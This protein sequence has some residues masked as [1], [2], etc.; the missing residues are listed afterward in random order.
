MVLLASALPQVVRQLERHPQA[1]R[2]KKMLVCAWQDKWENDSKSLQAIDTQHLIQSALQKHPTIESLSECLNRI[3][4]T[5][6]KKQEYQAIANAIVLHLGKLYGDS[7]EATQ[8]F[9]A[10]PSHITIARYTESESPSDGTYVGQP[11]ASE[12][13]TG[14]NP[15]DLR[16]EVM[17]YTNPLRV[18]ILLYAASEHK[19][20]LD[21]DDWANLKTKDLDTLLY[22]L[23]A[24]C[25]TFQQMETYLCAAADSLEERSECNQ[26]AGAILQ[27]MKRFY[28]EWEPGLQDAVCVARAKAETNELNAP[29]LITRIIADSATAS[30]NN[31][32]TRQVLPS[33]A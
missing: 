7:D 8:A 11:Q 13:R 12:V 21:A 26:A 30:T 17:R 16:L 6:N 14:Y 18:K 31:T 1:L 29:S 2:M 5:L 15:F 19:T 25:Q 9:T 27:C 33:E 24:D 23:Y 10:P 28:T 3:A 22:A 32:S 20:T 4:S